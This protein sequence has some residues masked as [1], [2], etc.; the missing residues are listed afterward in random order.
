MKTKTIIRFTVG[1]PVVLVVSICL[2]L[3]TAFL[4]CI[5]EDDPTLFFEDLSQIWRIN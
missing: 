3:G 2:L 4:Y 5:N 1:L